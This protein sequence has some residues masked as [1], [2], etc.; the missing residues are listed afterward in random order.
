MQP[1]DPAYTTQ[2]CFFCGIRNEVTLGVRQF[3]CVGCG[4][5][6]DRDFNASWKVL[7]RG[8][9]KIGQDMPEFTP[10]EILPPPLVPTPRASRVHEAGTIRDGGSCP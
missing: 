2:D 4:R 8:L 10:V 1:V 3:V 5:T 6:L 7:S 9:S